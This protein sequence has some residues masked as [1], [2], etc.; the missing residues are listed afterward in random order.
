MR[1]QAE[2]EPENG[3]KERIMKE[4]IV[5]ER[6][7]KNPQEKPGPETGAERPAEGVELPGPRGFGKGVRKRATVAVV[8]SGIAG[9]SAAY[10]L[11]KAGHR[12][13]VFEQGSI[14]G[15]RMSEVTL[16]SV[17]VVTG[18][19]IVF[20]FCEDMMELVRDVGL[21]DRL[22]EHPTQGRRVATG[23]GEYDG[24]TILSLLRAPVLGARSK[25]RLAALIPDILRARKSTDPNLAHTAAHLDDESLADYLTR[26]VGRDFMEDVVGP[27]FRAAWNWEPENISKAYFLSV[28]S[29]LG[30][31]DSTLTFAG[32]IGELTD[33][34]AS[35]LD[36]RCDTTVTAVLPGRDGGRTIRYRDPGGEGSL[37]A[38]VAVVAVQ[39][40]KVASLVPDLRPHERSLL[41]RVR[42]TKVG[43]VHYV[44]GR[45][46]ER[47]ERIYARTHPSKLAFYRALPGEPGEAGK[48]HRLY[49]ELTPQA[50]AE[51][52][53]RGKDGG[54]DAFIRPA[55]R[56]VYPSLDADVAEVHE[57]WWD[58]MLP[59]FYPGYPSALARYVGAE[60]AAP[61]EDLLLCG[62]YLSHAHTGGACASGR[63]GA[64]ALARRLAAGERRG[65]PVG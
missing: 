61:R 13:V 60:A 36:V 27:P 40:N 25:L 5:K 31:K 8:G 19:T 10:E 3:W 24:D 38:D 20:S 54:L 35:R 42:Y 63:R 33:E 6:I 23:R 65:A 44:L 53:E 64:R 58:E 18:A 51:Y 22:R 9:L 39:G 47:Y 41:D 28:V 32:G 45:A 11:H 50:V 14:P 48:P 49:C 29:H 34:L 46:P 59:E 7:V 12:V 57:Q 55:V 17:R 26:K 56:E 52:A 30:S 21:E 62:D 16:G 1:L 37:D 15:G 2:N 43:I 4:R